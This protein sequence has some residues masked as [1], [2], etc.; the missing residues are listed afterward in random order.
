MQ[1]LFLLIVIRTFYF[2]SLPN[3]PIALIDDI[4][5]A[6]GA[7]LFLLP[8]LFNYFGFK[9]LAKFCLCWLPSIIIIG[10]YIANNLIRT[11]Q[12]LISAL[13]QH[14]FLFSTERLHYSLFSWQIFPS[15]KGINC[16]LVDPLF[17][18]GFLRLYNQFIWRR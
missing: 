17:S 13:R 1:R 16:L 4:K 6:V 9:R 15:K 3:F 11:N 12:V 10:L 7:F 2:I 18:A 14:L 5:I 8:L